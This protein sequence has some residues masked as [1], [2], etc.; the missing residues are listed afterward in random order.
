MFVER[1]A[2]YV[3]AAP[4]G[5]R[6]AAGEAPKLVL[7]ALAYFIV[8][9]FGLKLASINPSATPVWP[10]TGLAIAVVLLWGYR[11]APAIFAAAFVVNYLTAGSALTSTSIA[12]GNTLEALATAYFV[13]WWA[14]GKHVFESPAGVGKFALICAATTTISATLGVSS[15]M[16]AGNAE[17]AHAAPV[18]L[19]WWLGDLAGAVVF[20]PVV[21]LWSLS[22]SRSRPLRK[23][24][25]IAIIYFAA[26]VVGILAFSPLIPQTA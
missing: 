21:L 14:D 18:W 5:T 7:V 22:L 10:A 16:L 24:T 15:L 1:A 9:Y 17:L 2:K 26:V 19:T 23:W 4:P 8:A 3:K 13:T 6:L 12:F 11:L 25:E 20:A